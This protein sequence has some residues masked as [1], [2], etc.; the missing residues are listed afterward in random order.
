MPRPGHRLQAQTSISIQQDWWEKFGWP[1]VGDNTQPTDRHWCQGFRAFLQLEPGAA[2]GM[3]AALVFDENRNRARQG[4]DT[5]RSHFKQRLPDTA[6]HWGRP[7]AG[8]KSSVLTTRQ[9]VD[10]A[11]AHH[12]E[13]PKWA[14]ASAV[15]VARSDSS[16]D[17]AAY[18]LIDR[19]V[20]LGCKSALYLTEK[21]KLD[22]MS[23]KRR[24]HVIMSR[25]QKIRPQ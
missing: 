3:L 7:A 10:I 5:L 8:R 17:R 22:N 13:I 24:E 1:V 9:C 12:Y 25:L 23:A 19:A 21:A 6:A 18:R 4:L 2:E 15:G 20:A 11:L 16:T 14:I